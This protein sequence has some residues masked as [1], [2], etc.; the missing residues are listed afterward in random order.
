MHERIRI[1]GKNLVAESESGKHRECAI[2]GATDS[3][4]VG[5]EQP[6]RV[7]CSRAGDVETIQKKICEI[8]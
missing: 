8:G 2:R 1:V 7:V 3:A 4:A 6:D 5:V